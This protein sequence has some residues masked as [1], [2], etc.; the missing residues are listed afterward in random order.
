[1]KKNKKRARKIILFIKA[2]IRLIDK[3][4][5]TPITKFILL[6]TD[7]MGKRTDR[8][9]RWLVKKNTLIFISL[10]I[11]IVAFFAIDNKSISL[12][13]SYAEV[14]Y[15]QK[16]D[17]I[18]NTETYVVDGLPETVD[19]TLI[20][21]KVDM[22]LAKQLSSGYVTVDISNLKEG[23]HKVALNYESNINSID[24]KL[25]PSTVNITIYPKVSTTKTAT[26][27]TINKESLDT[28]LT[29]SDVTIDKT[30][31]I[32][33]GAEHTIKE[34]ANVRALV[35]IQK[36]VDP[37]VGVMTLEDV[38]LIAYDTNGKVVEVEMV[39]SKV[40]A[41]INVDSP[42]K[43]VPIKV[44]PVG[45][46]QFGKA[47]SSITSSE[48]KVTIY[49]SESVIEKIEYFPVEVDVVKL[50]SNKEFN[51]SLVAPEGVRE[52]S[53]KNTKINITLG[54]EVSKEI[55]DVMIETTNLDSN[56]KAA[57]IG[58][59]SSIKTSV[60]VKGTQEVLNSL[61]EN[62]IKAIVDLSG[63]K[64]GDH[65]VE[66]KVTGDD[67]KAIYSPKTTKIKIRIS[68]K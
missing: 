25:D 23:T 46:V 53:I 38:P 1:M 41:T 40:T 57:A 65:E 63:Y 33:K 45:E 52:L 66:I 32:I 26:I 4:I 12:V 28:K 13:D 10:L 42:H 9:E 5:I 7:K 68:K 47:I 8:F 3:K 11:A 31:I 44:I 27:D 64:E 6:I 30:E 39:P 49:G 48:T 34:V 67:V 15:D 18:Y 20:G 61:D 35:D 56:Y 14:L 54:E 50:D 24:Y 16:V 58:G 29:V 22:Y 59:A 36:L 2:L 62:K 60:I 17:A 21:R 19:V 55:K 43:E 37:E 51:V